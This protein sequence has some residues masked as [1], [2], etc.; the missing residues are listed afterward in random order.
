MNFIF[1]GM[2]EFRKKEEEKESAR[3]EMERQRKLE[4]GEN[5]RQE[6]MSR[7]QKDQEEVLRL[8]GVNNG[9]GLEI[10]QLVSS[11]SQLR[12]KHTQLIYFFL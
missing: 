6:L 4:M 3:R 11:I 7:R 5:K 8:K 9:L 12:F 2:E 1:L 10:S